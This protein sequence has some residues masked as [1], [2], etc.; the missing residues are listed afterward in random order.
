MNGPDLLK[1]WRDA[2]GLTQKEAA[3]AIKVTAASICDW[4]S[5]KKA[6]TGDNL[7]RIEAATEGAVP[8]ESWCIDPV[9]VEAMRAVLVRR[10]R[11]LRR[12]K[13]A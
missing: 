9:V 2:H 8:I 10:G 7:I 13:A 6:P 5:G 4:E 1:Q 11:V 3:G 12:R